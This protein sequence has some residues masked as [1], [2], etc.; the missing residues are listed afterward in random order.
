[1]NKIEKLLVSFIVVIM[2][3]I[4]YAT[5]SKAADYTVGQSVTMTYAQYRDDPDL[6]CVEHHQNLRGTLTYKVIS[7]FI[8]S[9]LAK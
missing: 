1:M 9:T 8:L 6:F 5:I 4:G 3:I 7:H 2:A